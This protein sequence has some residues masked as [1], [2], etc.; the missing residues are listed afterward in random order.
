MNTFSNTLTLSQRPTSDEARRAA[1]L[2][3]LT[4]AGNAVW[5]SL[6]VPAA[7]QALKSI[8]TSPVTTKVADPAREAAEVRTMAQ[9]LMRTD[10]RFAAELFAAA[11]RHEVL[12]G[13]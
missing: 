6:G 4:R 7:I 11:D 9:A 13:V 2:A 3:T 8:G 10:P 12:H 1:L 5:R